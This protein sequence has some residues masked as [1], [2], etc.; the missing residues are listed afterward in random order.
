MI[1]SKADTGN[2]IFAIIIPRM[3]CPDCRQHGEEIY[4]LT[5]KREYDYVYLQDKDMD[6]FCVG[7]GK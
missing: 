3:S 7:S 5:N 2:R 1:D 4:A 6:V